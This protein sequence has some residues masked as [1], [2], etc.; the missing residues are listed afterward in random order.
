[1]SKNVNRRVKAEEF[2]VIEERRGDRDERKK[3]LDE[4]IDTP[5][6][7]DDNQNDDRFEED[8]DFFDNCC[9]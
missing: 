3:I 2:P 7:F 1:M 5:S 6:F 8:P 4:R 9:F